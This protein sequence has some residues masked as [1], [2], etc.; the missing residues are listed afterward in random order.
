MPLYQLASP[1]ML[2]G[3]EHASSI[4]PSASDEAGELY[5]LMAQSVPAAS[6]QPESTLIIPL[7]EPGDGVTLDFTFLASCDLLFVEIH[8]QPQPRMTYGH[9]AAYSS[10]AVNCPLPVGTLVRFPSTTNYL[11]ARPR[12]TTAIRA[13]TGTEEVASI[14]VSAKRPCLRPLEVGGEQAED[15]S[16]TLKGTSVYLLDLDGVK[17]TTRNKTDIPQRERDLNFVFRAMDI[18]KQEYSITT[19]LILQPD[20]Y[21]RM[22]FEQGDTHSD[23]RNVAFISCGL[24]SRVQNL[25][26]FRDREK[27]RLLLIGSV[28]MDNTTEPTLT[29]EDFSTG[30]RISRK[31]SPCPSNNIGLVTA[32]K[33]FQTVMQILFSDAY[34][35]CLEAFIDNLEGMFRPMELVAADLLKYTIE[36]AFRKVFRVIR[37]VKATALTDQSLNSPDL[38][39]RFFT[40][41][42]DNLCENLSDHQAMAKQ[43]AYFRLRLARRLEM[44]GESRSPGSNKELKKVI[45]RSSAV[46][47]EENREQSK[48]CAGYVGHQLGAVKKDGRPYKCRFGKDCSFQ[49]LSVQGKSKRKLEDLAAM[50]PHSA[51]QDFRRIID[52]KK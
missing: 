46:S 11:I 43:E 20:E 52:A 34:E 21:R 35:S 13:A 29:L 4:T 15:T 24:I 45:V 48:P 50:M 40:E 41:T 17:H 27:T 9:C 12:L 16:V 26:I 23:E 32:L 6:V 19:D 30:E 5:A 18:D 10:G 14:S 36:M 49:H 25:P 7:T 1:A 28:M 39:S 2:K 33:N 42:F 37:S 51:Q 22:I 8:D 3:V 47:P 44:T 38:C 31:S